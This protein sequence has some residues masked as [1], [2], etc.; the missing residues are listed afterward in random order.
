[1][2]RI[3]YGVDFSGGAQAG[4][5]IWLAELRAAKNKLVVE[6]LTPAYRLPGGGKKREAALAGLREFI[7]DETT[8]VFGLDTSL[9]LPQAVMLHD[10]WDEMVAHFADDY[11]SDDAFRER[12]REQT[13]GRELKRE[14]DI[15]ARTP[16]AAYNIRM[17][18]QTYYGIRDVVAPLVQSGAISVLPFHPPDPPRNWVI[19]VC[20]ASTL[21]RLSLYDS[22]KGKTYAQRKAR[23]RLIMI[24][25]RE[26]GILITPEQRDRLISNT[27]GDVVDSV[28]AAY[29]THL[30]LKAGRLHPDQFSERERC[31]GVVFF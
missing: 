25:Q 16:L 12:C 1:M 7:A 22:Y 2:A 14:T 3:V 5:K 10:S 19:E 4:R 24:L 15:T 20:P 21:K 11:P 9:G 31:E 28:L 18:R 29:A 27:D 30:A 26:H 6:S 8:A 17:Y 23:E 13:G